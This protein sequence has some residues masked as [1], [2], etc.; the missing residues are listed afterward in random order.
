MKIGYPCIN[1]SIPRASPSTFRLASYSENRL[2]QTVKGNLIHLDKILR[3]N[4]KNNLLFFRIS[5]DLIPFASHPICK[6][7]WSKLFQSEFEQ[8]GD[9]I[10][11]HDMRISMHPDQFVV[12]NSPI[13]KI[14]ENSVNE[15][16]YHSKILDAMHLNTTAK[17]QLHVGGIYGNKL[18]AIN[19]FVKTYNNNSTLVDDSIKRR[20]VIENDDHLFNLKDCLRI[21][22]QT[23]IPIVFDN[24]HHELF[25]NG[26]PLKIALQRAMSTW[27]KS[28]DGSP[29]VDYS[30]NNTGNKKDNKSRKGKHAERIDTVLFR[31]FLKETKGLDFDIMFEIKDKEKSALTG[32]KISKEIG[33]TVATIGVK[34]N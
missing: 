19:R 34:P 10:R 17:V 26:E 4:A 21:N 1:N 25:G 9:Y 32:L 15:L 20:L 22:E 3:Y 18:E 31:E 11:Q 12:L 13:N 29:I 27:N 8:I 33:M 24:F 16:R 2:I 7:D 28:I 23:G 6:L 14:L 30:S 5:S